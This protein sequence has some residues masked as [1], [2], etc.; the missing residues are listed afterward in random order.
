MPFLSKFCKLNFIRIHIYMFYTA[1]LQKNAQLYTLN[2]KCSKIYN[3]KKPP[4][5]VL[6]STIV[7]VQNIDLQST[8]FW[9][10]MSTIYK[11]NMG[12]IYNRHLSITPHMWM[13][14]KTNKNSKFPFR[15]LERTTSVH[16]Q[17]IYVWEK[18]NSCKQDTLTDI[19]VYICRCM[20][21]VQIYCA[22]LH[23]LYWWNVL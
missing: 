3:K 17:H 6:Q 10:L 23:N 8:I 19:M 12:K 16:K 5:Y 1:R 15:T 14:Y 2:P 22:T 7:W 20:Y 18:D 4:V 9:T 11:Q 21:T 13:W